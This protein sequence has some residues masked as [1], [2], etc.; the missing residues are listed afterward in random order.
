MGLITPVNGVVPRARERL[1]FT[2]R[3]SYSYEVSG[4]WLRSC[5]MFSDSDMFSQALLL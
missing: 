1:C 3:I 2:E 4:F 5:D